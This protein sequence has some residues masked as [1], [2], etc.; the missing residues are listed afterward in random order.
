[1]LKPKVISF[2]ALLALFCIMCI[3][4]NAEV[5]FRKAY[6]LQATDFTQEGEYT[7]EWCNG[8]PDGYGLFVATVTKGIGWHYIGEW[9]NGQLEGEG[10]IYRNNGTTSIGTFAGSHLI[11]SA[12]GKLPRYVG[13]LNSMKFHYSSCASVKDIMD[14]NI[15]EFSS[16]EAA[17]Q[18]GYTP[19]GRCDP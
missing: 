19:C 3:N 15:I 8:A 5:V 1:M 10:G 16:R 4:A 2:I 14:K 17:V 18:A 12:D 13:N 11:A 6:T 7:G 9:V